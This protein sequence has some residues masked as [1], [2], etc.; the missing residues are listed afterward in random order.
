[1]KLNL[2]AIVR[3]AGIDPRLVEL[4]MREGGSLTQIVSNLPYEI[5]GMA[6]VP[7]IR[8]VDINSPNTFDCRPLTPK[9]ISALITALRS[10]CSPGAELAFGYHHLSS[11]DDEDAPVEKTLACLI[12]KQQ[13]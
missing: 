1:M 8:A 13:R 2:S 12:V 10:E 7:E 6:A 4:H 9:Q 3:S 5:P 11:G